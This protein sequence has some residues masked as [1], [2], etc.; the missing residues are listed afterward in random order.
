VPTQENPDDWQRSLSDAVLRSVPAPSYPEQVAGKET[1]E[2]LVQERYEKVLVLGLGGMGRVW[3]GWD[4]HLGRNV[5]IKEPL[6]ERGAAHLLREARLTAKLEHAGVVAIHDMYEDEGRVHFVMALVRGKTLGESLDETDDRQSTT[7]YLRNVL[8]VTEAIAHAHRCGVVHRDLTPQNVIIDETEAARVI[9]WGLAAELGQC[10]AAR[11]GGTPGFVSPE[12][13]NNAP[14]DVRS[15]VWSIGALIHLVLYRVPPN[16]TVPKAAVS[17]ELA[18]IAKRCLSERPDERYPSAAEVAIDLRNWFEGRRVAAYDESFARALLR[19]ARLHS[20]AITGVVIALFLIGTAIGFGIWS[21]QHEAS[22]ALRAEKRANQRLADLLLKDARRGFETGDLWLARESIS[23][24]MKLAP[25][26]EAVGLRMRIDMAVFPKRTSQE[27]LG[28]CAKW[29]VESF[30]GPRVCLVSKEHLEGWQH[31]VRQWQRDLDAYEVRVVDDEVHVLSLGREL[32]VLSRMTGETLRT[33]VAAALFAARSGA[34]R[35]AVA[36]TEPLS[37]GPAKET[38]ANAVSVAYRDFY[39]C[40][41]GTA[42]QRANLAENKPA[43]ILASDLALAETDSEERLWLGLGHG[44]IKLAGSRERP[45][46]LGESLVDLRRIPNTPYLLV[47]GQVGSLRI[48]DTR[49]GRWAAS[50]PGT[51]S[52]AFIA[53]DGSI[54]RVSDGKLER[55]H[56]PKDAASG[57]YRTNHGFSQLAWSH[58][59]KKVGAGDGAGWIHVFEPRTGMNFPPISIGERVA[60]S[61]TAKNDGTGFLAFSMDSSTVQDIHESD[62]LLHSRAMAA[63]IGATRRIVVMDAAIPGA[64]IVLVAY[65]SGIRVLPENEITESLLTESDILDIEL[66]PDRRSA[67]L[68]GAKGLWH[69]IP[70]QAP[71]LL[72]WPEVPSRAAIAQ[73]G[74]VAL[75]TGSNLVI[76]TRAG[77]HEQAW[78]LPSDAITVSWQPGGDTIATGHLNGEVNLWRASTGELIAH[79]HHHGARISDLAFSPNGSMLAIASWDSSISFLAMTGQ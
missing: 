15:D 55:W 46:N 72:D 28:P 31:G 3:M 69:W 62:K 57:L 6:G 61:I 63:P 66:D 5:A 37:N 22:R 11:G 9:D 54:G 7:R 74:R 18:A 51:S 41:D 16:E 1:G 60:K 64:P 27:A 68:L 58:D 77:K 73:D 79:T 65:G 26:P 52:Q 10:D 35:I 20:Q 25:T 36:N 50:F 75:A 13:R 33:D 76:R 8:Q 4:N 49:Q 14:L 40:F 38:C 59:S 34:Q 44:D 29:L 32:T 45:L 12:Q 30:D 21:T 48:L 23:R 78:T 24:V 71:T 56:F 19:L 42:W 70:G 39:V 67:L 53:S 43:T 17:P 2:S 47:R